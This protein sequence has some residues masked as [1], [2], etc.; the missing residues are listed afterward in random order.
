MDDCPNVIVLAGPNGAGKSTVSRSLLAGALGIAHYVNA[1]TIAQGL[2][3]FRSESM[4][5]KAGRIMLEHLH[6]L[7]AERADFAFET[8]LA[9]RSFATWLRTLKNGGYRF[10]LFFISL[11]SADHAVQRVRERVRSGGHDVPEETVR[12]RF[13]RGLDNFFKL[14]RPLAD[15]WQFFDNSPTSEPKLIAEGT[16]TIETVAD[17]V[18]W[19]ELCARFRP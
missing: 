16:G 7:A 10:H 4:A 2:S 3:A 19:H 13:E 14:Y 11:P 15:I 5:V 17:P 1:D 9:T 6:D 12:R 8:T 18:R